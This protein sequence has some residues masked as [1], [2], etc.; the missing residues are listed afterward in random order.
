MN[1]R[2]DGPGEA[3][4]SRRRG[5]EGAGARPETGGP[6]PGGWRAL[7][8]LAALLLLASALAAVHGVARTIGPSLRRTAL[9]A[10]ET[11]PAASIVDFDDAAEEAGAFLTARDTVLVVVPWTMRAR[12][13]IRLYHLE[14]GPAVREALARQLGAQ[15]L[16]HVVQAGARVSLALTPARRSP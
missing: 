7:R 3:R 14:D 11:S 2:T 5:D 12:D 9:I 16:D 8:A 1:D 15:D 4:Q 10:H 6:R 13:L